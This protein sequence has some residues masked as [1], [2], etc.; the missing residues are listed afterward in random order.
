MRRTVEKDYGVN[1]INPM[2]N[3]INE[4]QNLLTE[5][6]NEG[7]VG[8]TKKYVLETMLKAFTKATNANNV[9]ITFLRDYDRQ[10]RLLN[11]AYGDWKAA[12]DVL[13]TLTA[14]KFDQKVIN[15]FDS[16]LKNITIAI[17]KINGEIGN[18]T[19]YKVK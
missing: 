17:N 18:M 6:P 12:A 4:V 8:T 3:V 2:V 15:D 14:D 13:T 19:R 1:F 9:S 7:S 16:I 5:Y 10:V 11:N